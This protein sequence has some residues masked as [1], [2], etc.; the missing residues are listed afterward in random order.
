MSERNHTMK[1]VSTDLVSRLESYRQ[2]LRKQYSKDV[3]FVEA[4]RQFAQNSVVNTDNFE[5]GIRRIG[6]KWYFKP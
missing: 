6:K 4:S 2:S 5:D 3:S 1:R